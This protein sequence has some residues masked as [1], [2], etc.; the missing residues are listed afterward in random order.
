VNGGDWDGTMIH[1]A[2]SSYNTQ[3]PEAIH[4]QCL[5][6]VLRRARSLEEQAEGGACASR[7]Q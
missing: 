7:G 6:H 1:D 2:L 5:A 3:F 4:Q